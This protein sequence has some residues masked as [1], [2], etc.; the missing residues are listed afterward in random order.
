[1]SVVTDASQVSLGDR[2]LIVCDIDEVVLEFLSPLTAFLRSHQYDLLPRS[3]RLHGN[4][5]SQL[6]GSEMGREQFD[7]LE[8]LFFES[9]DL[10]QRPAERAVETLHA[11]SEDADIV[12]LTAM[13][14]RHHGI[15]RRLLDQFDLSFDMI[16][17]EQP[18][19]PIVARLHD[20]RSLPVAFI[21]DIQ[22]NLLSVAEH[23]PECLLITMMANADF[24]PFAPAP[25][26]AIMAASDWVHAG[27][28][29]RQHFLTSVPKAATSSA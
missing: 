27:D 21:D 11:L 7:A 14:P 20:R 8:D 2:P 28:L 19:G 24:R 1:M 29:M 22:R 15:R 17:S 3:F 12:F 18:K 13:P 5:V 10:W 23:V 9:Q 4:I 25:V 16:A 6:D 26:G